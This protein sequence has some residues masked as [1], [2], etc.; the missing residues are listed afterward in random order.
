LQATPSNDVDLG[1]KVDF[2]SVETPEG[3]NF[4]DL[5]KAAR[6][7][8]DDESRVKEIQGVHFRLQRLATH[9]NQWEGEMI[10]IRMTNIPL[11]ASLSGKTD[12]VEL[13]DDEGIG[14]ETAFLYDPKLNV[15]AIQRNRM[16]G[17][18]SRF[19]RYFEQIG[20]LEEPITPTVVLEADAIE[21]L[22]HVSEVRKFRVRFAD[23]ENPSLLIG[24]NTETRQ[25]IGLIAAGKAPYAEIEIG[26]GFK[27]G[28]LPVK[29]VV[30]AAKRFY[31]WA[32]G[33]AS[34]EADI[35]KITVIGTYDDDS[36][37]EMNLLEYNMFEEI[38]VAL[39]KDR[40]LPYASRR[41]A[42]REVWG[43]RASQLNHI[44]TLGG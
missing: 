16:G 9:G 35:E 33:T 23:V 19:A 27:R 8:P 32:T 4:E 44:L 5:L 43:R 30:A 21:R 18:A 3:V 34:P 24:N 26:M 39:D 28:T 12:I 42:L 20:Q 7:L 2:Y 31:R 22:S 36:H 15:L 14:E 11:I 41:S 10:R 29:E 17:S 1:M 38:S 13:D 37:A 25:G 40:R 6:A